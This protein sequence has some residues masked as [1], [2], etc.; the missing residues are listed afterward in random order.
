MRLIPLAIVSC[1]TAAP[2]LALS[3]PAVS[4]KDAHIRTVAYDPLNRTPLVLQKG[5]VTNVTFV[6]WR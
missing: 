4:N 5:M 3:D 1:L 6:K 2:A